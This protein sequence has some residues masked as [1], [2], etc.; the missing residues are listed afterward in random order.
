MAEA[1]YSDA[2]NCHGLMAE[3]PWVDRPFR[4][5]EGLKLSRAGKDTA[6][7]LADDAG[8]YFD[9]QAALD[10]I[11]LYADLVIA[12]ESSDRP[13]TGEEIDAALGVNQ[14]GAPEGQGPEPE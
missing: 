10:E 2:C 14:G 7:T 5:S 6:V 12:A 4:R 13:L 9:E 1:S 11:D 8:E 3:M